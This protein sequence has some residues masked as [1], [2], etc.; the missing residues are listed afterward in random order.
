[1]PGTSKW[2]DFWLS[3]RYSAIWI[4]PS[5]PT[6]AEGIGCCLQSR[7]GQACPQTH[8][9]SQALHT[10]HKLAGRLKLETSRGRPMSISDSNVTVNFFLILKCTTNWNLPK[11]SCW[12]FLN[13]W[14][15]QNGKSNLLSN[16]KFGQCKKESNSGTSR[17]WQLLCEWKNLSEDKEGFRKKKVRYSWVNLSQSLKRLWIVTGIR[18]NNTAVDMRSAAGVRECSCWNLRLW[19]LRSL[20][21]WSKA[22][23]D[24]RQRDSDVHRLWVECI[25]FSC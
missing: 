5:S 1:M 3:D 25:L 12:I 20:L 8:H 10:K 18:W 16:C 23:L 2:V 14:N 22:P 19:M 17:K 11:W 9:S 21:C 24:W 6:N 13:V 7:H 4:D 15:L